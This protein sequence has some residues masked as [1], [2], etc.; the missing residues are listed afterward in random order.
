MP[1]EFQNLQAQK[2]ALVNLAAA[3]VKPTRMQIRPL[4]PDDFPTVLA[5]YQ[6]GLDTGVASFESH[7]PQ[8]EKWD[9]K[10]MKTGR[11][12]LEVDGIVQ[13]WTALTKVSERAVYRGV[14]ELTIYLHP[15]AQ[16]K[17]WGFQLMQELIRVSEAAGIWTLTAAIFPQNSASIALHEKAGFRKIGIRE[18]V[19]YRDG[20][21]HDNLLMEKRSKT[22]GLDRPAPTSPR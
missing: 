11:L 12:A 10:F 17:G 4:I 7:A 13:G 14:A 6:L 21:W 8:A 1:V 18:K 2:Q 3:A 16:G 5:I 20:I 9:S 19:A 15:N 22:V